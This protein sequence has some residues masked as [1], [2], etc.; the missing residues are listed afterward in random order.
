MENNQQALKA[1]A[2]STAEVTIIGVAGAAP[3][4]CMGGSLHSLLDLTGYGVSLSVLIATVIMVL[5]GLSYGDLAK[6]YNCAGGSY[7]YI[8]RIFGVKAGLWS[9]FVYYGVTF[10]T[11]ACPPTIFSTYLTSLTGLPGWLGWII[12]TVFMVGVTWFGVGLSAKATVLVFIVEMVLMLIPAFGVIGMSPE[13]MSFA[14]AFERS[15][16][17]SNGFNGL[18]LAVLVWV[19]AFVGVEAPAFMGEEMKSGGKGVKFAIPMSAAITGIL[20]VVCCAIWTIGIDEGIMAELIPS[21]DALAA[22]CSLY[23]YAAGETMVCISVMIAAVAC[24]LA[25]YSMAIRFM[26]DQ[27]RIGLLPKKLARVNKHQIPHLTMIIYVCISFVFCMYGLYGYSESGLFNGINDHFTV[28][29]INA[30][31]VYAFVCIANIKERWHDKGV[32][33][34]FAGKIFPLIAAAIIL[35]I[36]FF[37]SPMKYIILTLGWYAVA[38]ILAILLAKRV[39]KDQLSA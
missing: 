6:K 7:S 19:W 13:E 26:Y 11:S 10:T 16:T 12:F 29:G 14:L 39:D 18:F 36:I 30:T 1:G 21:G 8:A 24:G 17:A 5:V 25:M 23:G 33:A 28:M 2:V 20:Y 35:Y 9:A 34:F 38:L 32:G 4:M 37:T 31:T 22:Y 27:A 15:F 3:V